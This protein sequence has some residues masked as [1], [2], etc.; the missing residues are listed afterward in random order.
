M[1]RRDEPFDLRTAIERRPIPRTREIA[2][3]RQRPAGAA[4]AIDR[5]AG[6]ERA[7]GPPQ[8]ATH[9]VGRVPHTV[10]VDD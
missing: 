7:A 3:L 10:V 8:R 2:P 9:A 4:K 5:T 1:E 6:I